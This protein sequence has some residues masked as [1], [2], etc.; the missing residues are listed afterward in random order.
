LRHTPAPGRNLQ[1]SHYGDEEGPQ[2]LTVEDVLLAGNTGGNCGG[3]VSAEGFVSQ[4]HN[5][6][7]DGSCPALTGP[8]DLKKTAAKVGPLQDNGGPTLTHALLDGS[9]AIDAGGAANCPPTDQRGISRP[10]GPTCDIGA[11]EWQPTTPYLHVAPAGL[12][13]VAVAGALPPSSQPFTITNTGVGALAWIATEATPWLSVSP[14]NGA[15]PANPNVSVNQAGRPAST[16][17][18]SQWPRPTRAAAR[19][20]SS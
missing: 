6:S 16:R 20:P 18:P 8:G 2:Q 9:P 7:S 19:R 15:A 11:Y 3:A 1:H 10:Q 5:L 13:F 12:T 4:G 17:E 14:G